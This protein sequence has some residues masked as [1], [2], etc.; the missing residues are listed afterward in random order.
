MAQ[1]GID[2]VPAEPFSLRPI[3]VSA[4]APALM[5]GIAEGAV[6]P[7][8]ALTAR[9]LGGTV[10]V[11]SLVVALINIGSLV[12]N[13][14]SSLITARFGE[15]SAIIAAGA[16]SSAGMV[17]AMLS[18]NN[19]VLGAAMLL[20]GFANA[21]FGLARQSY[22]TDAVP[23]EMRAR[24]LS[25]LG[26]SARI[27]VF[28]GPFLGAGAIHLFGIRGAYGVAA[29]AALVAGSI[30]IFSNDLIAARENAGAARAAVTV[31]MVLR[32]HGRIFLTLGL[33]V[34]L[35]A[36]VRASR[37]V[38]IPLWAE[39][40]GM[41]PSGSSLIYGLAGA[42]DMITFYPAGKVMDR[43]GR[44]WV[45]IPSM[46]MMGTALMLIPTTA[47]F[48]T[49]M[50]TSMLLGFGNGIG[51]GMIMTLGADNA[52]ELGRPAFLGIWRLLS[53][54]GSC[55][56][57]VLLSAVTGAISLAVG[58][59][60]NGLVAILAAGVLWYWIP[61]TPAARKLRAGRGGAAEPRAGK[62]EVAG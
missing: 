34:V 14:P 60:C 62:A 10:A 3:M 47:G 42:I 32:S 59:V 11:A 6:L 25:T 5:F 17:L 36:A 22:L 12:S 50:L 28:I 52:P 51:A 24:A 40:L 38:V 21:V 19:L 7:V 27:G 41:S 54:T 58:V 44:R 45:A 48:V 37:Q 9:S 43:K 30:A 33:G 57:P 18:P 8:V 61:R 55:S 31:P 16:V 49:L 23:V 4:F 46:L 2:A 15:R 1:D 35:V 53:D 39:N 29:V 13:I 26:G 20:V 56:G